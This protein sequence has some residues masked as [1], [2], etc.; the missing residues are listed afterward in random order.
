V[1]MGK[2]STWP[3]KGVEC[4]L[5]CSN[6]G[7]GSEPCL[8]DG[9]RAASAMGFVSAI[10]STLSYHTQSSLCVTGVISSVGVHNTEVSLL[11]IVK[12]DSLY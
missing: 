4:K 5:I 9:L 3:T 7:C 2:S 6:R 12:R 10:S 1:V 8:E 11:F